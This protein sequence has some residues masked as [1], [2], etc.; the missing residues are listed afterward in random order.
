[1]NEDTHV[2]WR[3]WGPEAFAEADR[4]NKPVL[5]SLSA[6]WCA[7][8]HEMDTETYSEPRIAANVNDGFVPVRVDVDRQPRVRER[9]NMGGFPTTAFL[10]PEGK[11][12]TGAMY[13]GPDGM[14][15][16]LDRVREM[17][18]AKGNEAG[19]VPRALA[20]NPTPAGAVTPAI[21]EHLAGQLGEKYDERFAGWG[22][23]AKFPMPRTVE[24]ALKRERDQ[25]LRT[26][27]AVRDHLL[28]D[29]AGGF[30]RY[31]GDRGWG[32]V[33]H[34]KLLDTNAALVRAFA[35]AY[36]YT[37]E[38]VYREPA[39]QTIDYL[40]DELWTGLGIGGSQGPA[41]GSDYYLLDADER[42]ETTKPRTDLTV[43]AGGN[44]LAADA[45][46]TY[47]AYTDDETAREYAR[48]LLDTLR[49]DLVDEHGVVT[50]F[51]GDEA[52]ESLLLEDHA[53]V[54]AAFCRAQQVLGEGVDV[55]RAVA[56]AAI[57]ELYDEESF[58]DGPAEGT[59][60]L[61]KPLRP[62]DA[63]VEMADA[64]LDLAVLTGDDEYREIARETIGAF[65]G[66]ADRIGVQVASYGA[67]AG[68]LCRD[69]L[70]V[71]VAD[72]VGSDLHRAA[73]RIADHEKLVVPEAT[74]DEY[75]RGKAYLLDGDEAY[76][77]ETPSELME[78]VAERA[79]L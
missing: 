78:T 30:F 29:V 44:A 26:L 1:M 21:E 3:E 67:V 17:W 70:V 42:A 16:V 24:F 19:R 65:A 25:A 7:G 32:D 59:G 37:G 15:Q 49:T 50:H 71:A 66:A 79:Q 35:N 31:A 76:A 10:T 20:G 43:F 36:L 63:N 73:L 74:G 22:N 9:Y 48:R 34:E 12:L 40:T 57:D 52:S 58:R 4:T 51:A 46:L 23:D 53:R 62:I 27:D 68:R 14:R 6:T 33:H 8:C 72:E 11:L 77:A 2:E 54:V 18:D 28:D 45:F 55:A 39:E 41:E 69:P 60:M 61:D 38:D 56:D 13:L 64:L 5:L 75:E 47:H